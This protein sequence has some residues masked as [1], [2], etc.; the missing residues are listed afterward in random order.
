[1]QERRGIVQAPPTTAAAVDSSS[2]K[3]LQFPHLAGKP[4]CSFPTSPAGGS[5]GLVRA[6][7]EDHR[8]GQAIHAQGRDVD[9]AAAVGGELRRDK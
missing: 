9:L 4:M 1:M 6:R 3:M 8:G 2:S 7:G 5:S